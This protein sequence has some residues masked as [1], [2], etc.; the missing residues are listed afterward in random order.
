MKI[1]K[2]IQN[3]YL[4]IFTIF[5][6]A[7]IPLYPKI[8]L[9]DVEHTWVYVRIEDFIV[10]LAIAVWTILLLLKKVT[11]KTPLTIPILLFWIAGGLSTL[12]GVI[13]I[14]PT[15]SNVF[16]NVAL[17]SFLRGIEYIFLFFVAYSGIKDR[18]CISAIAI[19]LP[20]TLLLVVGYGFGQRYLGFPAYLTMN[21][22]FAKGTP[23]QLSQLSRISST[24]AGHY[25]LAGYLVLIIPIV[26]SIFFGFKNW[27]M[28]LFLLATAFSG[29][30][31]LFLTVSRISFFA[32]LLSFLALLI[33][34]RKKWFM[35]ALFI[36]IIASFGFFPTLL[37]RFSSTVSE[38][39]VLVDAKTGA[40]IG[41]ARIVP[42]EYFKDKIVLAQAFP[43]E[44]TNV[45]LTDTS[46][47]I[48]P[49]YKIPQQAVL[50]FE[51][52]TSN[53]ENLPQG[54]SYINLSLS[55]VTG[56]SR[57]YFFEKSANRA[58][59]ISTE[60]HVFLGDYVIKRAKAYDISFT[61]RFQGEWPNTLLAFK[62]NIFLG[63]GYGSVSMAVDNNYLRILGETGLLGFISYFSIFIIAGIYI[64]KL[65]PKL[66]SPLAKS[67]ILGFIAGT[68][69]LAVNAILIDVFVASKIAF[70]YWLLMGIAMGILTLHREETFNLYGEIKRVIT[71]SYAIIA[72]IFII[73]FITFSS[74]I[75]NYF[76]GDD[77]TWLRWAADCT[78]CLSFST[79][80]DYFGN[81][82]GFFY[83]PGTKIFFDLMYSAFWLNQAAFHFVSIFL[84][85]IAATLVFLI[86]KK[87]LKNFAMSVVAV[88]TFLI[89]SGYLE[90]VLWISAIGH[91]F[92]AVFILLSLLMFILW[93]EKKR[94]IYLIFSIISIFLSL[95]FYEIGVVA[96]ILIVLYNLIY[97]G[98]TGRDSISKKVIYGI[99]FLPLLP[100][101]LMRY[102][103]QSHW[104][105]GDYSYN[106]IKLPF[107]VVG[108]LLG[109]F[110]LT[111]FGP[112][113]LGIYE[114]LRI[115]S[116]NNMLLT[117]FG[118]LIL[119][120]LL[121]KVCRS[122]VK[123]ME[124]REKKIVIF[125]ILFSVISLLP[126][127]GLGNITSRYSYLFSFGFVLLLTVFLK[128]IYQ[129]LLSNG[130]YIASTII[131]LIIIVFSSF[132]L[133]QMQR[134]QTDW[135]EAGEKT[136]S[137]L[138]SLDWVY[139]H[140]S[141]RDTKQLYFV[142]VPIRNGEA[143]VFSVGLTDAS[144][145]VFRE[146][147]VKVYQS[148][149][150][151]QAFA[152]L[153]S[154]YGK[155]FKF[156]DSGKP[157]EMI[158]NLQGEIVPVIQK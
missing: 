32:L 16:S 101:L 111:L 62:R 152:D 27:F 46:S 87:I 140:Y 115:L 98:E 146:K 55:P 3:N 63:S 136:K 109:Y 129:Y 79:V 29:L 157:I 139:A 26:V 88:F 31:I 13:L 73:I 158:R 84:H 108:N 74:I 36:I 150:V 7:F 89:L 1:F 33:F 6:L 39:D 42:A 138:T 2:W 148:Q 80:I 28:K 76:V 130:K 45:D 35:V 99:A 144:W 85:F 77:F 122:L 142:N 151:E 40:S 127:L 14:F 8:P 119:L 132:Q 141:E 18:R 110:S 97:G 155:I 131:V 17:L 90:I 44:A 58:G 11:L 125:G 112:A 114:K 5:L 54:S 21:E 70:T 19:I 92:N 49:Y 121:I 134:I 22:E 153:G 137:F 116:R 147:D 41:Q 96:P 124:A 60:I 78:R 128:N 15:L 135:K 154:S 43:N 133:F 52:N 9:L 57:E 72:Y 103:A 64:G 65:L 67:F 118:L 156:D 59:V 93:K 71:S 61:T 20:I 56:K 51:P 106:L 94:N 104:F 143:W 53:G 50:V 100:Y 83:R 24:F 75:T 30:I 86:A 126:Y 105:S 34:Q 10:V 37:Q 25:D 102:F 82:N 4:F 120:L 81:A 91:L 68:L 47:L 38:V 117:A 145:L 149:S 23:M 48:Y 107:N 12:H 113:S 123:K 69:G 66:E 95:M